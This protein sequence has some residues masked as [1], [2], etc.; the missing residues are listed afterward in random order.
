MVKVFLQQCKEGSESGCDMKASSPETREQYGL[1]LLPNFSRTAPAGTVVSLEWF[2][3]CSSGRNVAAVDGEELEAMCRNS[4][5]QRRQSCRPAA[6]RKQQDMTKMVLD[7]HNVFKGCQT[8]GLK[9]I[10]MSTTDLSGRSVP[11]MSI[12]SKATVDLNS[13][14]FDEISNGTSIEIGFG[15]LF[16]TINLV[17]NHSSWYQY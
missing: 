6:R 7:F 1:A 2:C 17:V 3:G 11:D 14:A 15:G 4:S 5:G 13:T 8:I 16:I 9:V 10:D 12:I